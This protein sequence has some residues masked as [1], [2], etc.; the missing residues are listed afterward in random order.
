M[1][2][3]EIED[4]NGRKLYFF[5]FDKSVASIVDKSTLISCYLHPVGSYYF[6]IIPQGNVTNN[7]R[8]KAF[9]WDNKSY[10]ALEFKELIKNG[11]IKL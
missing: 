3:K 2:T 8:C 1:I 6:D 7:L 5:V 11:K 10:T 4:L 9:N